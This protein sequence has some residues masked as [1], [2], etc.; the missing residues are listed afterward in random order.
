MELN[1]KETKLIVAG[2]IGIILLVVTALIAFIWWLL[3]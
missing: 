2:L 3:P 1:E